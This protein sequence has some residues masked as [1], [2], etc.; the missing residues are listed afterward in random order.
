MAVETNRSY[1]Q[2]NSIR[3]SHLDCDHLMCRNFDGSLM[4]LMFQNKNSSHLFGQ[5][6]VGQ[7][8]IF[9]SCTERKKMIGFN[10]KTRKLLQTNMTQN[11]M[12]MK[13]KF[14]KYFMTAW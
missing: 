9:G 13:K 2:R 8:V 3:I 7:A 1:F 5:K 11:E 10:K 14:G 4:F 12:R 6:V